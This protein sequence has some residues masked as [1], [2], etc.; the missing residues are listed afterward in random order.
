MNKKIVAREWLIFLVSICFGLII[1]P[2]FL[3]LYFSDE[4]K[5]WW[6]F[7]PV[8][9]GEESDSTLA[10]VFVIAPYIILQIIRSIVWAKKQFKNDI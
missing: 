7:Y 3:C 1:V 6:F 4:L 10:R 5:D 2:F 9:I 8:L